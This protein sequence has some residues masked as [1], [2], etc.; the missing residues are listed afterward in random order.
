[1]KFQK[2]HQYFRWFSKRAAKLPRWLVATAALPSR[3]Q[4]CLAVT[5]RRR[6]IWFS[7][8]NARLCQHRTFS[9]N[10]RVTASL[11]RPM[12]RVVH[13]GILCSFSYRSALQMCHHGVRASLRGRRVAAS[14][15]GK[16]DGVVQSFGRPYCK[17]SRICGHCELTPPVVPVRTSFCRGRFRDQSL[18]VKLLW[19]RCCSSGSRCRQSTCG[20]G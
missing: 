19:Q 20:G 6:C 16:K 13:R 8:G 17:R 9:K 1:M 3:Y 5:N 18:C 10:W 11:S 7:L 12:S 4:T 14:R 2:N 15:W